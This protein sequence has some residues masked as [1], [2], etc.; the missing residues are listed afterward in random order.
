MYNW[1]ME[2]D[3]VQCLVYFAQFD[4]A[5]TM[6]ELKKY[7][8]TPVTPARLDKKLQ[9]LV[10]EGRI[11]YISCRDNI[12]RY[13]LGEYSISAKKMETRLSNSLT[14]LREARKYCYVL[15]ILP[16]IQLIGVSGSVSMM[17]AGSGDDIDLFIIAAKQR[18]WSA[19]LGAILVARCLGVHRRYGQ[20]NV[21]DH[22][23]LNMFFDGSNILVGKRKQNH[24]VAHEVLQM[25]PIVVKNN[26][27]HAFLSI[28][29]WVYSYYPNA[30]AANNVGNIVKK[31]SIMALILEF[32]L[33]LGDR[34]FGQLIEYFARIIQLCS[35]RRHQTNEIVTNTQ[36]WFFPNDYE[37]K[38]LMGSKDGE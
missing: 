2:S 13:T 9:I 16:A 31:H 33:M 18:M 19:R 38:V 7:L 37:K 26:I 36:L 6:D 12:N 3:I 1:L 34:V 32:I 8:S 11:Q 22:M 35:I 17:N 29:K 28:N 25:K 15:S 10:C 24:Y 4:Y 5:P 30:K 14:K 21:K 27:Y 20:K 23:C